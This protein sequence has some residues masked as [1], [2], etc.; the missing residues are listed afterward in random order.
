[1]DGIDRERKVGDA[2][3]YTIYSLDMCSRG[4]EMILLTAKDAGMFSVEW[5]SQYP[6]MDMYIACYCLFL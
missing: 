3:F 5:S 2:G 4:E 6:P 1:M